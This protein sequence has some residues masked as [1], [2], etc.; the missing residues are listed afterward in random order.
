MIVTQSYLRI[1]I[2]VCLALSS[3]FTICFS[4]DNTFPTDYIGERIT[5]ED[6]ISSEGATCFLRDRHGF[7]WIGTVR[8][9]NRYDGYSFKSFFHREN[10]NKSI[11]DDYIQCL[12]EDQDG[13]IWIGTAY[14]GLNKYDPAADAFTHY[15]L[16]KDDP[17]QLS[18]SSI[19]S[20]CTDKS[21]DIWFAAHLPDI[22]SIYKVDNQTERIECISYEADNP[23]LPL[24]IHSHTIIRDSENNMWVGYREGLLKYDTLKQ[25]F[26]KYGL[27]AYKDDSWSSE[28]TAL[29]E[30]LDGKLWIGSWGGGLYQFNRNTNNFQ[31]F[32]HDTG[33]PDSLSSTKIA[34]ITEDNNG[35]LIVRTFG[36]IDFL[37]KQSGQLTIWK[38]PEYE[39]RY[40]YQTQKSIYWDTSGI[41]WF[42]GPPGRSEHAG[43]YKLSLKRKDFTHFNIEHLQ[44]EN[45]DINWIN[46][47]LQDGDGNIWVGGSSMGLV[48][49]VCSQ[50]P[51]LLNHYPLNPHDQNRLISEDISAIFQDR[52]GFLWIACWETG[53]LNRFDFSGN[54]ENYIRHEPE[55]H[56]HSGLKYVPGN[57]FL[58]YEDNAFSG[59]GSMRIH[60]HKD[61]Y[62]WI[63][64]GTGLELFD[65]ASGDFYSFDLGPE[66]N[67]YRDL[68]L[69][70]SIAE[71]ESGCL[72]IGTMHQGLF[73]MIPPFTLNPPGKASAKKLVS[74][75]FDQDTPKDLGELMITSLCV[76]RVHKEIDIWIG[77]KGGGLF[78]LRSSK[79]SD[80][81]DV[82]Q[83]VRYSTDDGLSDDV[84]Y[85]IQEDNNG[86]LWLS[87]ENGLSRFSSQTKV[88]RVYNESDGLPVQHFH[89]LSSH[90]GKD[91]QMF[92][93]GENGLLVF[94]P[95]SIVDNPNVPPVVI[96]GLKIFNEPVPIGDDSPLKKTITETT[97]IELDYRENYLSFEFAALNYVNTEKN[98]YKYKLEGIDRDWIDA[99]IARTASYSNLRHGK[100]TFKVIGSNNDGIWN[101]EGRSLRIIIHP[102]PWL[103]WWAYC[104]YL[105]LILGLIRWYRNYLLNRAKLQT[106]Y[107]VERIEKEKVQ[108]LDH[109]KSRFFA[110]ISHEFRTPL[111]LLLG[112]IEDKL[113]TSQN[114]DQ[115]ELRILE[116][117]QRNAK[118]LQRLINQ[119]LDLSK[120]ETGKARLKVVEGDISG[121]SRSIAQS[122]LSLAESRNI[123][124]QLKISKHTIQA[125]FDPDI[126]EK[127]LVNL[128]SNAFKF[129]PENGSISISMQN[130]Q[131][132][133]TNVSVS[134]E[135][136]IIDTGKGIPEEQAEQIFERFYQVSSSDSREFEGTGIGLAL[137]K[138]LAEM[139]HGNINVKSTTGKG[140][141]FTV[142]L[143]CS[144]DHFNEDEIGSGKAALT[145][146]DEFPPDEESVEEAKT[147]LE[148]V[149]PTDTYTPLIVIVEDNADLRQ[150]ISQN[151]EDHYQIHEAKNGS[152][153]LN[154]IIEIIPDLV[155]TDLMMPEMDGLE[156]CKRVKKDER[157]S[158]IPMIM[159][160]AKADKES[161]IEGLE[162]GVDGYLVKPFDADELK[163]RVRNMIEQQ[164]RTREKLYKEFV[165][166]DGYSEVKSAEERFL[167][168][169]IEHIRTHIS[170]PG[171]N[172]RNLSRI[173]DI[174]EMQLYRK[175]KGATNMSPGELIRNT[176]LKSSLVLLKQDYDNISQVAYQVGFSDH[177]YFSKCFRK[178]YGM[179]PKAYAEGMIDIL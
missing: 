41:L 26:V 110:N 177:S 76:P 158:H 92:F 77:T 167:Q 93:G 53:V 90:K 163:I 153:G 11:S 72:W 15:P 61:G 58:K 127:I 64:R 170:D 109:L 33:H 136:K 25:R 62:F 118:R 42:S 22:Q 4:Q 139:H 27:E 29:Y 178:L 122:F 39:E 128:I 142:F 145:D 108:E 101:E 8:G 164:K 60:E 124:Y 114:L 115:K 119:L 37:N 159:V 65:P 154:K 49:I 138:E 173:M 19:M 174:S 63:A 68:P 51:P 87:T 56:V 79:L 147:I 31:R 52:A 28:P 70:T 144:R 44:I 69:I 130:R 143:P 160:T 89:W 150:Y 23:K 88:F 18:T 7:L 48:K 12:C 126:L 107:E 116:I 100:Y 35:S 176:R 162:T 32:N 103:S 6:G 67:D 98:Q 94:N 17:F 84:V 45:P 1:L 57:R 134:V 80:A 141:T 75:Q 82:E 54:A 2:L 50:S 97:E 78:G 140:S 166:G 104:V 152:D 20:V 10:D 123:N 81:E 137:C 46:S 102:P 71:D 148:N 151:L 146:I 43:I 13:M 16:N 112:P 129:T 132:E 155:I 135:F 59:A 111:T 66:N 175:L 172:V 171:F 74:Y 133:S 40:E 91:G 21:G 117:M 3:Q 85:G 161:R 95:D 99:G 9:L 168:K 86:D 30:D 106:A 165:F 34:A 83:F 5:I 73:R 179:T 156:M 96:T 113:K 120:L 131:H 105:L 121:F 157:T 38:D 24:F 14:G 149:A 47:I 36:G 55:S 169:T 125:F